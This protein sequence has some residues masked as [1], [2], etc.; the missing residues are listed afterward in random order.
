MLKAFSVYNAEV[1][2]CQGMGFIT[3]TLLMYMEEEDAFWGLV[4]L[5]DAYGMSGLFKPGFPA[6]SQCFTIFNSLLEGFL[7]SLAEHLQENGVNVDLYCP[8]WFLTLFIVTLPFALVLRVW[9]IF[10]YEGMVGIFLVA[11]SLLKIYECMYSEL[12]ELCL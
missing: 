2:Y 5:C 6:L 7:P 12:R 9:D 11:I 4:R 1:G 10:L 3:A 8:Q